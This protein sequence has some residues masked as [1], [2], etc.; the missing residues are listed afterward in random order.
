M[1]DLSLPR[2]A[3]HDQLVTIKEA[4]QR[5]SVS[6]DTIRRWDRRGKIETVRGEANRRMVPQREIERLLDHKTADPV[7]RTSS[8]R[9]RIPCVVTKVEVDGLLARIEMQSTEP[10]RLVAIITKEAALD[11][12]LSAGSSATALVKATSMMVERKDESS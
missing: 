8:T 12:E 7:A 6:M 1:P 9:N 10:A 11:L 3:P 2:N 5:L 4:A